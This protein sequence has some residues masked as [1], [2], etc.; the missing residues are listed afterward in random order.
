MNVKIGTL[1][2]IE[3]ARL[4]S[5][6]TGRDTFC[7]SNLIIDLD[8]GKLFLSDNTGCQRIAVSDIKL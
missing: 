8:S 2:D 3:I 5:S 1:Y 6:E 7:N 4:Q